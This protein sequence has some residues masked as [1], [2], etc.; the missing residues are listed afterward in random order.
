MAK[1][2]SNNI[3][4]VGIDPGF[5]GGM[6][7][8]RLD[9]E[10]LSLVDMPVTTTGEGD[11]PPLPPPARSGNGRGKKPRAVKTGTGGANRVDGAAVSE[12][13]DSLPPVSLAVIESVH[14]MPRQ[15][16]KSMFS[17]G[18][19]LGVLL[20]VLA[21]RG[22]PTEEVSPQVWQRG[23]LDG[24]PGQG[25]AR[26]MT[27]ASGVFPGVELRTPRGR[28]LDGR[29]DALALAWYAAR[30]GIY[31]MRNLAETRRI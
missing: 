9:G 25:K 4:V 20:G 8:I 15:G 7:A 28:Q 12:W 14:S 24:I 3:V 23:I 1:R 31:T 27:W 26:V 18:C 16:V 29:A 21:A 10:L 6:A 2:D 19:G 13:I 11:V 5:F 30:V 17:F 22:V